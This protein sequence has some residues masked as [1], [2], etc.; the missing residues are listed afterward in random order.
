MTANVSNTVIIIAPMVANIVKM[1]SDI[2]HDLQTRWFCYSTLHNV[3][4]IG[5]KVF[6]V[7]NLVGGLIGA[8]GGPW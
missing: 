5:G 3:G 1:I 4:L 8:V 2:I 6:F 7:L